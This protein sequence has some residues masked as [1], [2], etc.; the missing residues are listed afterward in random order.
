MGVYLDHHAATPVGEAARR[1]MEAAREV[2]W[3]NP[4][5]VH[6][7]G[8]ASRAIL[9]RAR[10]RVA[11]AIGA[12]PADVVLASGGTEACNL[13]VLGLAGARAGHVVTTEIEHP[14]VAAAIEVLSAAGWGV[15]RLPVPRGRPPSGEEVSRAI[16]DDTRLVAIQM[17][18]H[19]TGTV[20]PID[21]YATVCRARGVPLA[22][23]AIQA[24]GKVPI[25][26]AS[27]GASA[28]AI[29]SHKI[30]GPAGAAALWIARDASVEA[31]VVGGAQERGRRAGTPDVVAL[32]GFGAACAA[33]PAR[34]ASM[35]SI[36]IR[37]DRLE[38]RVVELGGVVAA[39]EGP[40]APTAVNAAF[41][42][43]RGT[44]LVAALDLEG[45]AASSGA[46]CSSGVD[47][48][49]AVIT[50]MHADEP[51]RAASS[52]RLSL[53]PE[54]RDEDVS[55]AL[56]ALERVLSRPPA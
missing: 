37:R 53:G 18:N 12:A 34:L 45:V 48:P 23:D 40:R 24:L 6:R 20:L 35:E 26:V 52:L 3:A 47:R 22:V 32:A 51:W 54:T 50:A 39:T 31:R 9:E 17:I 30:G 5:S 14:S 38:R 36:A 28:V 33:L 27:L 41:R 4:S 46:A 15:T 25:D 10:E 2:A 42:G 11:A 49:S 55:A 16:T 19:E 44:A 13:A 1:E 21:A 43:W 7:P 29:A 56:A 8:R